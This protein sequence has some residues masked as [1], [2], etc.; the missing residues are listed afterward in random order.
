MDGQESCKVCKLSLPL[1]NAL[2]LYPHANMICLL[3]NYKLLA[4]TL[5]ERMLSTGG[6]GTRDLIADLIPTDCSDL[7]VNT[8]VFAMLIH[9]FYCFKIGSYKFLTEGCSVY[10]LTA[11]VISMPPLHPISHGPRLVK[12]LQLA[13]TPFSRL[14]LAPLTQ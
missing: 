9:S 11:Y 7:L 5:L 13:P 10:W 1:W 4:L 3:S 12:Q 2:S 14:Q 6:N 8:H